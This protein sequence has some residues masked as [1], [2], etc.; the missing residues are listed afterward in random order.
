M[1]G[2]N[3]E[4]LGPILSDAKKLTCSNNFYNV[5]YRGESTAKNIKDILAVEW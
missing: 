5:Y 4:H 3:R 1:F 2:L